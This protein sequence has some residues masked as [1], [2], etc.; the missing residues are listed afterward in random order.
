VILREQDEML[1]KEYA[2]NEEYIIRFH[3]RALILL[4]WPWDNDRLSK[5]PHRPFQKRAY[6]ISN[7]W[8]LWHKAKE[9]HLDIQLS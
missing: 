1:S 8:N 3:D 6:E 2:V 9:M 7:G 5:H 4:C